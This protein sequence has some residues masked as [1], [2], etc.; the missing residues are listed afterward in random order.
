MSYMPHLLLLLFTCIINEGILEDCRNKTCRH[1]EFYGKVY[2]RFGSLKILDILP[3]LVN[4]SCHLDTRE[5][6]LHFKWQTENQVLGS[7]HSFILLLNLLSIE[8]LP[9]LKKKIRLQK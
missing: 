3:K 5:M 1:L 9:S 2:V 6:A 8:K 4:E 7:H